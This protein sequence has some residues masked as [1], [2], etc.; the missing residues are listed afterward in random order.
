MVNEHPTSKLI[1][2]AGTD[3]EVGKTYVASLLASSLYGQGRRVGVYKPVASGCRSERGQLIAD[4]AVS[5]W[6]AAGRPKTLDDVCPQR[7]VAPLAPPAAAEAEGKTLDA[8]QMLTGLKQWQSQFDV[9]IVEGA[10][11][12]LSPLAEGLLNVEFYQELSNACLLIVSANRLGT[13]HQTMATCESA[14]GRGVAPIGIVLCNPK[15]EADVSCR[16]NR[17]QLGRYCRTPVLT[18]IAFGANAID[19]S[20]A[21]AIAGISP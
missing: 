18:E 17:Q 14:M 1:F 7:F 21:N 9:T 19:P 6:Q 16:T 20:V 8:Q 10:G 15:H 4:D 11:G 5:L 2:V 3:T 13:I 12:L